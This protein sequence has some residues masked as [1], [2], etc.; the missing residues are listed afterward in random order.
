MDTPAMGFPEVGIP[1]IQSMTSLPVDQFPAPAIPAGHLPRPR[2][3]VF[4]TAQA[5]KYARRTEWICRCIG[6]IYNNIPNIE[7]KSSAPPTKL[8]QILV[9]VDPINLKSV[10]PPTHPEF[11]LFGAICPHLRPHACT[12]IRHIP[13][14]PTASSAAPACLLGSWLKTLVTFVIIYITAAAS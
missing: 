14:K 9:G 13:R 12:H 11:R 7:Q 10:G 8:P 1:G 5:R 2:A 3:S 4:A 6:Q